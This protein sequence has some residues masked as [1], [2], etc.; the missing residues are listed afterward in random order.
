MAGRPGSRVSIVPEADIIEVDA[1]GNEKWR[2]MALGP[3]LAT[4]IQTLEWVARRRLIKN[5]VLCATCQQPAHRGID[6]IQGG[7]YEHDVVVHQRHFVGP[8][9]PDIHTQNIEN[10]WMRAKK[11]LRRQHGTTAELFHSYLAEFLWRNRVRN[12]RFGG[13]MAAIIQIYPLN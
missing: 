5:E 3:E 12:N 8:S 7:V 1:I 4:I 2:L 9:D 6:Q 10:T 11:K 13:I